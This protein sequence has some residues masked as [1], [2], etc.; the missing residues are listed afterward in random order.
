VPLGA[1]PRFDDGTNAG[2]GEC[3]AF[4]IFYIMEEESCRYLR[5]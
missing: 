3:P 1:S 2:L 5:L 4:F